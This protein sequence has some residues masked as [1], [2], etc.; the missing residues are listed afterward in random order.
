M[1]HILF[2][3][4]IFVSLSLHSE[5]NL[6][7]DN[8][9]NHNLRNLPAPQ[10]IN[11]IENNGE[12]VLSWDPVESDI[13]GN[14]VTPDYYNIYKAEDLAQPN[15]TVIGT[16]LGHTYTLPQN[17]ASNDIAF[18]K[19][20]AYNQS[21]VINENLILI[22]GGS[23]H[24]GV[25]NV[26]IT[27]FLLSKY[28]VTQAEYEAI[29]GSNPAIGYGEG[30]DYPV[31]FV[32]WY[33][34][35]IYCNLRSMEEGYTPCYNYNNEGTDPNDWSGEFTSNNYIHTNFTCDFAAN[36][37]RLPTEMEWMYA[38]KGGSLT[39]E[40]GY[41]LYS[42]TNNVN[43]LVDYAWYSENNV[44]EG[45]KMVGTK[46]SNLL[47]LYDMS[48]NVYEFCWDINGS[49]STENLSNPTGPTDGNSRINHGGGWWH[50]QASCQ[51]TNRY[52]HIPTH[53]NRG[54]GFRIAKSL[55]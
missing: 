40:S 51:I 8:P 48:G 2:F 6:N 33:D 50:T 54:L 36:G 42:G 30:D 28:E 43:E 20:T 22:N 49:L 53:K 3:L 35:V 14:P 24:N 44:P 7:E 16:S 18:F 1:K 26:T 5:S 12:F 15:Y 41:P 29:N 27:S 4:L 55:D 13:Y 11:I 34:A 17:I 52:N 23:F 46:Q 9:N 32:S 47:G 39:P 19:V 38:A 21:T 10:N 25:A 37:Y 45:T 31:Y